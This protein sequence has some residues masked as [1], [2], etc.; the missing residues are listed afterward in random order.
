MR[1][2]NMELRAQRVLGNIDGLGLN[3]HA[4]H[5][6]TESKKDWGACVHRDAEFKWITL[7][8]VFL[9]FASVHIEHNLPD[10]MRFSGAWESSSSQTALLH[11]EG[12]LEPVEDADICCFSFHCS[13]GYLSFL[14]M[15][16]RGMVMACVLVLQCVSA[17]V[18][19]GA[20]GGGR[21]GVLIGRLLSSMGRML[22]FRVEIKQHET[23]TLTHVSRGPPNELGLG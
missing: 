22:T 4:V 12:D 13:Y 1:D 9:R 2:D 3:K 16:Q 21:S 14:A 11:G 7:V 5:T 20:A 8:R 10:L 18:L 15:K 19:V 17:N 23:F 6:E